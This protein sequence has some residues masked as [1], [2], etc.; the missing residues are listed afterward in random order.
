MV[1]HEISWALTFHWS[2]CGKYVESFVS[3]NLI[4]AYKYKENHAG[5]LL[6][7]DYGLT[8]YEKTF[9]INDRFFQK[10]SRSKKN[11]LWE[12][13]MN[14]W[15]LKCLTVFLY[16]V[17]KNEPSQICGR[18]SLKNFKGYGLPKA[19]HTPSKLLKAAFHKFCL[20]HSWILSPIYASIFLRPQ[21]VLI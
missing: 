15:K 5:Q 3:T 1:H 17:F 19:D 10:A 6:L 20:V 13:L 18:Q 4:Y 9:K 12:R 2:Y 7:W 21:K 16:K 8:L 11:M 14:E